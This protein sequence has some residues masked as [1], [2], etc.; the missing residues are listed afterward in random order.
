MRPL[1]L[2]LCMCAAACG[3][4]P[5]RSPAAPSAI[6][7]A[8]SSALD[9]STNVEVTFTK[10]ITDF[11][12]WPVL[13]LGGV[14]GGDVAAGT[15]GGQGVVTSLAGEKIFMLQATYVVNAG[16]RSFTAEIHGTQINKSNRA[17]LNGVITDGW[18][19]GARV[20]VEYDVLDCSLAEGG[21]GAPAGTPC[22][23]G[24]IRIAG[25]S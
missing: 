10:W 8:S 1:V 25:A 2:G 23:Q 11:S 7:S 14:V 20:H 15:V 6:A 4:Q 3:S 24:T 22:F 21:A 18:R 13:P 16:D 19:A 5:S 12:A 9:R 17:V